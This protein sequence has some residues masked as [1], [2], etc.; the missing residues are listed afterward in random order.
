MDFTLPDAPILHRRNK[1]QLTFT[2]TFYFVQNMKTQLFKPSVIALSL[3]IALITAA[4]KE[5]ELMPE[6]TPKNGAA[7]SGDLAILQFDGAKFGKSIETYM[8]GKVAGYGYT[9]FHDGQLVAG[10]GG[11]WARKPFESTPTR[12]SDQ[13]S[14]VPVSS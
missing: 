7:R 1:H 12:H 6:S 5:N 3:A 11:G 14:P 8:N 4:C 9:V 13:I 10:G 2:Q